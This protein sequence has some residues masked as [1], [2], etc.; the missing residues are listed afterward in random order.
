MYPVWQSGAELANS[1]TVPDYNKYNS[2]SY[3][4]LTSQ[5]LELYLAGGLKTIASTPRRKAA[6]Y[7]SLVSSRAFGTE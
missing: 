1:Y 6:T 7:T 2:L 3:S 5:Y 4:S